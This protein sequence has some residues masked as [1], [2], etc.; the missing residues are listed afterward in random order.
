MRPHPHAL[1]D[2]VFDELD[3]SSSVPLHAQVTEVL[4]REVRRG[5]LPHGALME[6]ERSLTE[7]FGLGTW[8]VQRA[9]G[10]LVASG[11]VVRQPGIGT[12][13]IG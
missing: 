4:R 12:R 3:G 11:V 8:V 10:E 6:S 5:A 9:M 13:V 7:R 1:P 2:D